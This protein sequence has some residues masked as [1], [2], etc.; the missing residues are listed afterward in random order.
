MY[1]YIYIRVHIY[2][3]VFTYTGGYSLESNHKSFG[4]SLLVGDS[5]KHHRPW[6]RE[7]L[8]PHRSRGGE[9]RSLGADGA[10]RGLTYPG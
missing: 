5:C 2:T 7:S 10:L 6:L 8:L 1:I 4:N 9:R 3:R